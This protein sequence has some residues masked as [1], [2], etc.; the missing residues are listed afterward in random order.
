M[1]TVIVSDYRGYYEC[2]NTVETK[3]IFLLKV[4]YHL[5]K[6]Y[7]VWAFPTLWMARIYYKLTN[8]RLYRGTNVHF[9]KYVPGTNQVTYW[10]PWMNFH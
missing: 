7:R 2:I 10:Q 3:S 4:E 8:K 1:A 6:G 5:F 9:E